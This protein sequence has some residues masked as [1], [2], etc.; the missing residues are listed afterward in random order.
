M[1][2][3]QKSLIIALITIA[4]I[5]FLGSKEHF[6]GFIMIYLFLIPMMYL[7][8]KKKK[9]TLW[10]TRIIIYLIVFPILSLFLPWK[11]LIA[12]FIGSLIAGL[13]LSGEKH[14]KVE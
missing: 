4:V 10:Q 8:E 2:I 12:L 13:L 7:I 1:K 9:L 14:G 6:V 3:W 11:D 5:Y